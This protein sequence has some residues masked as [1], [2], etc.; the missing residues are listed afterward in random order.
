MSL[1]ADITTE[2]EAEP[3]RHK[4]AIDATQ[5]EADTIAML[6][7]LDGMRGLETETRAVISEWLQKYMIERNAITA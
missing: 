1:Y 2:R 3:T 4:I 6:Y 5:D 7:Q